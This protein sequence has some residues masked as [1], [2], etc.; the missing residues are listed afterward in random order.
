MTTE[1]VAPETLHAWA[2]YLQASEEARRRGDRR[3]GTDHL[4]LALFE[5]PSTEAVLGVNLQQARQALELLDREALAGVGLGPGADAPPLAMRAVPK[6]PRI[7][8]VAKKDRFRMTP[9]AK[10]VLEEAYKP[11][12][13]R[14]FQVTG[15]EVL[16]QILALQPPDPA[17]VLLD[18][19]G[20][21]TS[22]VRRR[23][24]A[25]APDS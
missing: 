12:G 21:H 17:A 20:V 18:A 9:A 5:D 16:A 4:L 3:T 23:L 13:H 6:K 7:R 14:K 10:K 25:L 1:P 24:D 2:I 15:P 19:L 22:D 8:D 11:E